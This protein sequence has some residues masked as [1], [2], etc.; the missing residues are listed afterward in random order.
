MVGDYGFDVAHAAIK[1]SLRVFHL[2][3]LGTGFDLGKC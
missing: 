2:K 3:I 1:L